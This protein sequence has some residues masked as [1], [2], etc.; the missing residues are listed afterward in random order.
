VHRSSC[1]HDSNAGERKG[2]ILARH[3]WRNSAS[4][5]AIVSTMRPADR[6]EA[7]IAASALVTSSGMICARSTPPCAKFSWKYR[8]RA[9]PSR[10]AEGSSAATGVM[11][12]GSVADATD[13]SAT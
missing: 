12:A 11:L 3:N 5:A 9:R 7:A 8:P 1:F 4:G 6:P 10:T 2:R 13:R